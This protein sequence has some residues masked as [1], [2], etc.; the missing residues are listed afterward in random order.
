MK[1][2]RF[3]EIEGLRAYL[4][5]WVMFGHAWQLTQFM[6]G[7]I[8]SKILGLNHNAVTVFMIV[9]GFVIAHLININP[10]PYRSYISKRFFRL[11][12]LF[13][14]CGVAGWLTYPMMIDVVT[15]V[16]W[17]S[18]DSWQHMR[19]SRI[20]R[21]DTMSQVPM[22]HIVSHLTLLHGVVPFEALP[23]ASR[24]I[25]GPAWSI[26]LE[27]QFYLIAPM[28]VYLFRSAGGTLIVSLSALLSYGAYKFGVFGSHD[29]SFLP[30]A[31]I[32]FIV[33]V[34]CRAV[35]PILRGIAADP[36]M[37]SAIS[38]VLILIVADRPLGLF[39]WFAIYPFLVWRQP[40]VASKLIGV[41]L[42]N[43]G[44]MWIGR[45]SYSIYLAHYP[46]LILAAWLMVKAE[47]DVSKSVMFMVLLA[48]SL[49][50]VPLSGLLYNYVERPGI[51]A[52]KKLAIFLN[53]EGQ[54]VAVKDLRQ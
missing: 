50:V 10:E 9:S 29:M 35:L 23:E 19:Q 36:L 5:L 42:A 54:K 33:G 49:I 16:P 39:I 45:A 44:I 4:A 46:V 24:T 26:S 12:P 22:A 20:L 11:W 47:P 40:G 25:L 28:M 21:F 51:Q 15:S 3:D 52:G 8:L 17:A 6:P 18:S 27:W 41:A 13:I 7:N 14:L 34:V 53:G 1:A 2:D 43:R 32:Y 31:V 37:V 30:A 38:S 48:A